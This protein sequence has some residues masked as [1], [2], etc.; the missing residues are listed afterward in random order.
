MN[1]HD[2]T[3]TELSAGLAAKRFSSRE[4]VDALLGRIAKADAK[5]H[6]FTEVYASEAK[7]LA[8]AAD[9]ARASGFPL[10]PLH[11][12]PI[13]YKDLCDIAGR[14]G[15]GGSKMFEK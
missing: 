12:L 11:G 9:K 8:D 3:L 1:L 5:L 4:V 13:A 6:A 2:L 15:A 14:V 7:T 10:G